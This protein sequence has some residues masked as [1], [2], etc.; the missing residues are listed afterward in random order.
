MQQSHDADSIKQRET[1]IDI[2]VKGVVRYL[3]ESS[4][5]D[6]PLNSSESPK[7]GLSSSRTDRSL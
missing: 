6:S 2:L 4:K 3:T 5:T 7:D 1:I